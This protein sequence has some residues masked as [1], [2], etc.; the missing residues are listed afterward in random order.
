M[1]R[2]SPK[3]ASCTSLG[4][5]IT[6]LLALLIASPAAH[7]DKN[8]VARYKYKVTRFDYHAKGQL[9]GGKFQPVCTPAEDALWGGDITTDDAE[10]SALGKVGDASLTIHGHGTNGE[11][12][13]KTMIDS[14]FTA[15]HRETTACEH[16]SESASSTSNC[17]GDLESEMNVLVDISGGVG[18]RARI[19]WNFFQDNGQGNLV[20]NTFQCVEPFE[21]SDGLGD[22]NCTKGTTIANLDKFTSKTVRLPFQCRSSTTT[23]PPGRVYTKFGAVAKAK[24][25]LFLTRTKQR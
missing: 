14:K 4:I 9:T 10:L 8:G 18:N 25:A 16:E 1:G 21:F 15:T 12:E 17:T 19:T 11:L 6:A 13:A 7:A 23:P 20:P 24:G 3:R 5:V 22:M 2:I